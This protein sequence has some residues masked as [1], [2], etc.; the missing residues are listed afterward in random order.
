MSTPVRVIGVLM[1]KH[2]K[3]E[4]RE[5]NWRELGIS[6]GACGVRLGLWEKGTV[7]F[8]GL[9]DCP[10]AAGAR[11]RPPGGGGGGGDSEER[12]LTYY[13]HISWPSLWS[14]AHALTPRR[15]CPANVSIARGPARY[16]ILEA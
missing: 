15:F 14:R 4:W 2:H 7:V 11:L 1:G 16:L 10:H 6:G 12:R 13:S 5:L 3:L 9:V 8:V